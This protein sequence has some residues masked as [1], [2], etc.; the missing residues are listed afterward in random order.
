MDKISAKIKQQKKVHDHQEYEVIF[1]VSSHQ[2][3]FN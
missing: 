3:N 1:N 2:G